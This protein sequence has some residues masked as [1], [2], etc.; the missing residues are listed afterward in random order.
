MM[1]VARRLAALLS[2]A[3]LGPAVNAD[4]VV[5]VCNR[6]VDAYTEALQG[7]ELALGRMPEVVDP[8]STDENAL[9]A[10]ARRDPGKLF[11]AVGKDALHALSV[12]KTV[13][14][15]VGTMMLR[16]DAA[17][18]GAPSAG[19]VVLD[20]PS[21]RLFEELHS[22]FPEK[23]RLGVLVSANDERGGLAAH[24]REMGFSVEFAEVETPQRLLAAFLSLKGRADLVV[25]L[26][27]A[28]LYNSATVRPLI[29]ASLE[30]RL[31]IVGFSSTF[32]RAGSGGGSLRRLSRCRPPGRRTCPAVRSG[33]RG[34]PGGSAQKAQRGGEPAGSKVARP[35]LCPRQ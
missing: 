18:E 13:S 33:P 17:A 19:E 32:V 30:N 29:L 25:L 35:E 28:R 20:V 16:E 15:V 3:M 34:P 26:P 31:P 27:N 24:G 14:P 23:M 9:G 22:L 10:M 12:A 11:I 2:F 5:V 21:R 6:S 8:A 7:I 4:R 1:R